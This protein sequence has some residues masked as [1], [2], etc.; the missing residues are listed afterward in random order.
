MIVPREG[1]HLLIVRDRVL[2]RIFM[3]GYV[4]NHRLYVA[5]VGSPPFI[6]DQ[7]VVEGVLI[8]AWVYV[9]PVGD[10]PTDFALGWDIKSA[11]RRLV[12]GLS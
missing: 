7:A 4:T 10:L 9:G 1:E 6:D 5:P 2:G 11:Y 8:S 3:L 12:A